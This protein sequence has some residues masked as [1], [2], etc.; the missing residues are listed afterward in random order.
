[1]TKRQC[2]Y[3]SR[4]L[5]D[6]KTGRPRDYCSVGC[7][8]AGEYEIRRVSRR[9]EE[10]EGVAHRLEQ[11]TAEYALPNSGVRDWQREKHASQVQVVDHQIARARER[12]RDLLDD[13]VVATGRERDS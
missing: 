13:D 2:R 5:P 3:C 12:M 8:R 1:V 7:R 6:A 4:D 10:L 9:L 11:G